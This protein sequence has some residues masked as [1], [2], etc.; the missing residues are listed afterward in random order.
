MGAE[1]GHYSFN[2]I[3]KYLSRFGEMR[4]R[5]MPDDQTDSDGSAPHSIALPPKTPSGTTFAFTIDKNMNLC[6]NTGPG[7]C[8]DW[9]EIVCKSSGGSQTGADEGRQD[10][11]CYKLSRACFIYDKTR[12]FVLGVD[13]HNMEIWKLPRG[14]IGASV[15]A[16]RA[17]RLK[18]RNGIENINFSIRPS[19]F[20][21]IYGGS[22]SGKTMLIERILSPEY[23]AVGLV[24]KW[25]FKKPFI[26]L[27]NCWAK[28]RGRYKG[29]IL[30]DGVQ[31]DQAIDGIAYLPQKVALPDKLT[32]REIFELAA[33]DRGVKGVSRRMK[34]IDRVLSWCALD[35]SV[36]EKKYGILSG[37]QKRRVSLAV[38][39][40]REKTKLL[41]TD[42]PTTGL[43]ISSEL[44]VMYALRT[45]S[46]H[47]ITVMTVTHSI[48]ACRLFDRV[49]ILKKPPHRRVSRLAFNGLW[50]DASAKFPGL[51][52]R[53]ILERY[54]D[55]EDPAGLDATE[56][57][58]GDE[59]TIW[60]FET[61]GESS[62]GR[63]NGAEKTAKPK[64]R[65]AAIVKLCLSV[66]LFIPKQI[67]YGV[68][69]LVCR[70]YRWLLSDFT[71]TVKWIKTA[72]LI[73]I[74]NVRRL[75][76]FA[77]LALFCAIII[78]LGASHIDKAID[79]NV[80][81]ITL[82][83]LTGSW[84]CAIYA[85]MCVE[86]QLEFFAWENFSGLS[87]LSFVVGMFSSMLIPATVIALVFNCGMFFSINDERAAQWVLT[88]SEA[89]FNT[90]KSKKC[91]VL[92][93]KCISMI[94]RDE[95][96][97]PQTIFNSPIREVW[98]ALNDENGDFDEGLMTKK[99][100]KAKNIKYSYN[101]NISP[102]YQFIRALLSM[103]VICLFGCSLGM[104]FRSLFKDNVISIVAIVVSYILFLM[105]S[106]AFVYNS[107]ELFGP[108]IFLSPIPLSAKVGHTGLGILI[109][110]LLS[111][112][113]ISRFAVS[114][115]VY[116]V[117]EFD[118]QWGKCDLWTKIFRLIFAHEEVVLLLL[119]FVLVI[120]MAFLYDWKTR[121]W[122]RISR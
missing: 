120:L 72:F 41:I 55:P 8:C 103:I 11:F 115:M 22:G 84:L 46:R 78:Q 102:F 66:L 20:V 1:H 121:N 108:I 122:R 81:I 60:P 80:M 49:L 77:L 79:A 19:E 32:C 44:A 90:L 45:I 16:N 40:L 99:E 38:S 10:E 9:G 107:K 58:I 54:T 86:E 47:G 94:K 15:S 89:V 29:E 2:M 111:F 75:Y 91:E 93:E 26:S 39:L 27:G 42:E 50:E 83:T 48:A 104:F 82:M 36:L 24:R 57:T 87:P 98:K 96:I 88:N 30:I 51:S 43:D 37:G 105:F 6:L 34:M 3:R 17:T 71:Q 13:P 69:W 76:Y 67:Y 52:D 85:C 70:L 97:N 5:R 31:P 7:L 101:K 14:K 114:S 56:K 73:G 64:S 28:L 106:R 112:C 25:L 61:T 23:H 100:D 113:S 74:R 53:E 116:S 4:F 118:F 18:N 92:S 68:H 109:P 21:G 33:V 62:G 95:L 63:E 12:S 59:G 35:E 65:F 117:F 119:T 110:A